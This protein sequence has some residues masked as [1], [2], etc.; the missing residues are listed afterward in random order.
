MAKAA[1][2]FNDIQGLLLSLRLPEWSSDDIVSS[3]RSIKNFIKLRQDICTTLDII[4]SKLRM[5]QGV[6]KPTDQEVLQ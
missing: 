1:P 4:S 2:L 3:E 6:P 5:K